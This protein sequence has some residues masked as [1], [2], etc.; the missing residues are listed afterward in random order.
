M[1]TPKVLMFFKILPVLLRIPDNISTFAPKVEFVKSE[2]TD[3][4]LTLTGDWQEKV[5]G[6]KS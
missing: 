6:K 4:D 3:T 1:K 2:G 5:R